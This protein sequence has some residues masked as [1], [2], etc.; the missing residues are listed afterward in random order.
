[1][2]VPI[3]E[4]SP[5]SSSDP[6]ISNY[7]S[8]PG[9]RVALAI[10]IGARCSA[11]STVQAAMQPG[12]TA[13]RLPEPCAF[14]DRK[15]SRCSVIRPTETKGIAMGLVNFLTAMGLFIGQPPAFFALLQ[16]LAQDADQARRG[17]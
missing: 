6:A 16:G 15:L 5:D 2:S 3:Q 12:T 17:R 7:S 9:A 11:R 8:T 13:S 10:A 4:E 14:L 1:M